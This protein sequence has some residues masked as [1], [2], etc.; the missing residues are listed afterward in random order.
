[1]LQLVEE[2]LVSGWDDPRMPTLS[3]LRRRGVRPEALRAFAAAIGVTKY[4]G[5]TE[6]S[7]F[8]SCIRDDLNLV[9]LRR[10]AVLRPIKVVLTNIKRASKQNVILVFMVS[11]FR[12]HQL[13]CFRQHCHPINNCCKPRIH[14]RSKQRCCWQCKRR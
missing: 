4:N 7:V 3:G 2:G 5:L 14:C 12:V 11:G 13:K 8:E 10:L 1:M 6:V 9:A